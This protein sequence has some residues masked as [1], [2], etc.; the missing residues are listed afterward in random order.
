MDRLENVATP[1]TAAA[2]VVPDSVP[3]PGLGPR[4]MVTLAVEAVMVLAK[5]SCTVTRTEGAMEV[6]A[7]AFAG[8]T[9]NASWL[10]AAGTT[11]CCWGDGLT[12]LPPFSTFTKGDPALVSL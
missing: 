3:P 12:R 5:A 1:L 9:V 6:P 4:A 8:W 11:V 7:T 2:V 10:A